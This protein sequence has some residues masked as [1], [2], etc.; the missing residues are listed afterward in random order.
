MPEG[1]EVC[2]L[3]EIINEIFSG[4]ILT[5]IQVLEYKNIISLGNIELQTKLRNVTSVGKLII[6]NFDYINNQTKQRNDNSFGTA[7]TITFNLGRFGEFLDISHL[8]NDTDKNNDYKSTLKINFNYENSI[9]VIMKFSSFIDLYFIDTIKDSRITVYDSNSYNVL[10]DKIDSLRPDYLKDSIE[11][12]MN[13][14]Q[15]MRTRRR[16]IYKALIDQKG[17][18]GIG[19]YL[20]CEI[21]YRSR[22]SP[23]RK[24]NS[25]ND[26]EIFSLLET[27][28][29]TM[30]LAYSRN[31][32]GYW[33]KTG[34]TPGTKNYRPEVKL[35]DNAIFEFQVYQKEG[36]DSFGNPIIGDKSI[37][38][39][40][41]V[42]W[43]PKMQL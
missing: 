8:R 17:G 5:G 18:S 1:P 43:V 42:W 31:Q 40:R 23:L 7:M 26:N 13:S 39:R 6:M 33:E 11:D 36:K 32:T 15:K 19:N 29:I 12:I 21:L 30:K 37:V 28:C 25:L 35:F 16:S 27:I 24:C 34:M 14:L 20:A 10:S 41:T 4:N 22:I 3:S 38:N 9:R 2:R